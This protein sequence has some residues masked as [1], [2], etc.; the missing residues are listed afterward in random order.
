MIDE[1]ER[2]IKEQ[3]EEIFQLNRKVREFW[4]LPV[5]VGAHRVGLPEGKTD[6]E[7]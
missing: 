5:E 3:E 7:R 4:G 6:P 1:S 2:K